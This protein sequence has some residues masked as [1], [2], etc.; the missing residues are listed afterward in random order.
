MY[1]RE[2]E[3]GHEPCAVNKG[4]S[5]CC[6]LALALV[7]PFKGGQAR[8]GEVLLDDARSMK[9]NRHGGMELGSRCDDGSQKIGTVKE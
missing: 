2:G 5:R 7:R 6:W 8:D 3:H 9:M 1:G 4:N